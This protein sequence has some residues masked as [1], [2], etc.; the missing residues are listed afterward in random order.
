[1][2]SLIDEW[3][4]G[5]EIILDWSC[6]SLDHSEVYPYPHE[7]QLQQWL[8][9]SYH[10]SMNF[11]ERNLNIRQDIRQLE[12]GAHTVIQFLL[13]YPVSLTPAEPNGTPRVSSYA[14]GEDYHQ[15]S[16]QLLGDLRT[17]LEAK[18]YQA[19][20]FRSFADSAPVFERDLAQLLGLG[21]LGKNAC[22]IN[23]KF[24]SSFFLIGLVTD[25][26]LKEKSQLTPA[27]DFCGGCTKCLDICPTE[28]IEAPGVIRAKDCISY[29][30]I[31]HSGSIDSELG[32]KMSDWV[33]GCDLCQQV[34]PWNHK[35]IQSTPP[36][37][38]SK[39]WQMDARSWLEVL[40]KGGSFKSTF[41][42]SPLFRGGRKK[43]L[44]NLLWYIHNSGDD[45]NKQV[46]EQ[47][48]ALEDE[49]LKSELN[50][51]F[52]KKLD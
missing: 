25:L 16:Y 39:P 43:L 14:Q 27:Q 8:D 35:Q 50:S 19:D 38:G 12:P 2:K 49:P 41:K 45:S 40:K 20:I 13:S 51:I 30:T 7:E 11:M 18:G 46:V 5:Q 23:K 34:C 4:Q 10:G 37:V 48:I 1:L 21:W 29:L 42:G 22:L 15:K 6:A 31:E 36:Q 28:A 32:S 33:F 3:V 9:K 52:Q 47:V 17:F 26:E 24:G 44:R